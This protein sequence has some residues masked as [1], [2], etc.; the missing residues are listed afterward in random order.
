M[1]KTLNINIGNSIIHIEE[2]AYE[3]LTAYLN[4]IKAHFSTSPDHF[5]IVTDIENRIAEML[6]ELLSQHQRQVV[7]PQDVAQV[8]AQMGT[9][10]QFE[11]VDEETESV[12]TPGHEGGKEAVPGYR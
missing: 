1:K 4:E 2:E 3:M 12:E 11:E 10:K 5:E 9:V 8:V 7:E 6:T